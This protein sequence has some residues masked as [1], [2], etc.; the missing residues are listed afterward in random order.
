MG[1]YGAWSGVLPE[2]LGP[3]PGT[4]NSTC[5]AIDIDDVEGES[6]EFT[7]LQIGWC[8][9]TMNHVFTG[10]P[11]SPSLTIPPRALILSCASSFAGMLGSF[12]TIA[13]MAGGTLL[14]WFSMKPFLS[15]KLKSLVALCCFESALAFLFIA[16]AVKPLSTLGHPVN[17]PSI[18]LA[19]CWSGFFRGGID[20]LVFELST[21]EAYPIP[22]GTVGSLLTMFCHMVMIGFLSVPVSIQNQG[23]M[24][25]MA[26]IMTICLVTT[27]Y[28]NQI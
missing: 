13:G 17:F 10:S 2:I 26:I 5:A 8:Q 15:Q 14:G 3:A 20:P 24:V 21:E 12:S 23:V 9:Q 7:P 28:H 1:F 27:N 25:S 18:L 6:G 22:P 11:T 16:L 19:C 4:V